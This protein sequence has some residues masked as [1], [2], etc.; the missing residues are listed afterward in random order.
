MPDPV[1]ICSYLA[2]L[3]QICSLFPLTIK[4]LKEG[5]EEKKLIFMEFFKDLNLDL[6]LVYNQGGLQ[7]WG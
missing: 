5:Q 1:A 7:N 4:T 6:F 2:L 3:L